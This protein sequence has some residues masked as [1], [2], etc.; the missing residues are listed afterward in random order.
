[1]KFVPMR[2]AHLAAIAEL[3]R[4][5]FSAPWSE[6]ALREELGNDCACFLTAEDEESGAVCGYIG[7]HIV[8]D[9][10]YIAN[11]AVSPDCR[12]QGI[13]TKLV[14]EMIRQA[15]VRGLAF[16]TLE[17]RESNA[18]A[19]ALYESCGFVRVGVRKKYYT[20]PTESAVL[21]TLEF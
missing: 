13:G 16:L 18:P 10:G 1:M 20:S 6:D 12:R 14:R 19:I 15:R 11:V 5:C 3:E 17:A 4:Q 8:L 7:C 9:E 2:E 21:M